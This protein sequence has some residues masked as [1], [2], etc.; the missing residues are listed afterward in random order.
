M[1]LPNDVIGLVS[2][3]KKYITFWKREQLLGHIMYWDLQFNDINKEE[4]IV[5]S[6]TRRWEEITLA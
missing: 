5:H 4:I 2:Y 6:L 1:H 3:G